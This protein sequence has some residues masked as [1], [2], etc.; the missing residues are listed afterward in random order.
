[1][2]PDGN[3]GIY[4][5]LKRSG[6]IDDMIKR[7]VEFLH[8]YG[9]DN[10]LT[11]SLD[12]IFLGICIEKGVQCGNKVVW[13]AN[14]SEKVG[15]TVMNQEKM[16]IIE[17]SEIPS[18]MRDAVDSS[19]KLLFGAANICNH[20]LSLD[21]IINKVLPNLGS[22]YHSASKKIPYMDPISRETIVPSHNNGVKLEMFIFDV[23]PLADKWVVVEAARSEE[24]SPVK[25]EP[26]NAQDSPDTA[27]QAISAQGKRWLEAVG[28]VVHG[29]GVCEISPLVSYG[30]EGLEKYKGVVLDTPVY[31]D[32]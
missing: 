29:D 26:G 20:F 16:C 23:F 13:R 25:N 8:I 22:T 4:N 14:A 3:G 6:S 5:A 1:M 27:L 30:G 21:F 17:Y 11:K 24:F 31:L 9:I 15:V 28:A 2:A 19:G 7:G 18:A 32:S 10:V 12:P